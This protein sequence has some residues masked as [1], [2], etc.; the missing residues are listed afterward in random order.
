MIVEGIAHVVYDLSLPIEE[1]K[2]K[3]KVFGSIKDTADYLGISEKR[4]VSNAK[5][6]KRIEVNG[7]QFAIRVCTKEVKLEKTRQ[8]L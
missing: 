7:R 8:Y 6:G 2:S 3:A 1:R 4:V 5:P